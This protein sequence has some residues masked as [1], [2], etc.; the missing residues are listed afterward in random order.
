MAAWKGGDMKDTYFD[1]LKVRL[2]T[3]CSNVN[4]CERQKDLERNRVNYGCAISWAQ[5]MRDFGHDVDLPV[6]DNDG[7]LR[8]AKIVIDG[9]VY[10]DFEATRKKIE[11]QSKSEFVREYQNISHERIKA[12]EMD[13]PGLIV[14]LSTYGIKTQI[15]AAGAFRRAFPRRLFCLGIGRGFCFPLIPPSLAPIVSYIL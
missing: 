9:E 3:D 10:I 4:D 14:Y 1:N 5:V 13:F 11:N 2:F 7:F 8:I 15:W 12:P 6:Y